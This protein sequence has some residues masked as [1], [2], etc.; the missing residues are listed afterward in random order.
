MN[1]TAQNGIQ[2]IDQLQNETRLLLFL[3]NVVS[4][5]DI[6]LIYLNFCRKSKQVKNKIVQERKSEFM[7]DLPK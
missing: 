4:I 2:L 1:M 7:F 6:K 3:S 5:H